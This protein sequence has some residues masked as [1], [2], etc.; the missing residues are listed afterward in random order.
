LRA[1]KNQ[2]L[3][4]P[5]RQRKNRDPLTFVLVAGLLAIVSAVACAI[6]A[7]RAARVDPML[8][9]RNQ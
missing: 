9:L 1:R 3:T 6:P 8:V 7:V 5:L 4:P 2:D